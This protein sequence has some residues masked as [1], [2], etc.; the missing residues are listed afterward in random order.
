MI[1]HLR[2]SWLIPALAIAVVVAVAGSF[3]I[4]SRPIALADVLSSL[5]S[6]PSA[7]GEIPHIVWYLRAPRTAL[8]LVTGAALAVAGAIAQAWT[9]NP[10]ADPGFIGVTAGAAFAVALGLTFGL[11]TGGVLGLAGKTGLALIGAAV[12]AALVVAVSRSSEDPLTLILVG[13]G[14]SAAL[15]AATMLLSLNATAV[16]DGLRQWFVGSTSGRGLSDIAI[17]GAGLVL[18]GALA[19][20]VARPL[21]LLAMGHEQAIALGTSPAV[22]RGLA[23]TSVVVLAG[24]ATAAV[25]PVA[26]VGFAG[27]HLIRPLTGPALTRLLVPTALA[28]SAIT[29]AADILGRVIMRPGELEVS[30]VLAIVGA[31]LMILAV[32]HGVHGESRVRLPRLRRSVAR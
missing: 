20:W 1:G 4:G 12:T 29:L 6:G 5:T 11:A 19:T 8:A 16:L 25:G 17:A 10:L 3:A 2:T 13:L 31:P 30:V 7:Q 27:P 32:R 24:T 9:R 28:G 23:A 26:F 14:V 15:Q 22:T 21:D 18:G